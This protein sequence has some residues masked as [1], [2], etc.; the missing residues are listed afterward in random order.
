MKNKVNLI[1]N[2]GRDPE[3]R[4]MPNGD[5]VV[6]LAIATSERWTDKA[7]GE[8][9]ENTEWHRVVIFNQHLC[10]IAEQYL[11]KGSKVDLDDGKLQ[12][13]KWTDKDGIERYTTE[14][15]LDRFGGELV[16]LDTASKN[17]PGF[18]D[19][20]SAYG[21]TSTKTNANAAPTGGSPADLDDEIPL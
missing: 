7:T 5:K 2:L 20:P 6:N 13:R 17:G 11:K 21:N 8:K 14:V 9:K 18:A 19:D 4:S 15:V 16:M 3:V 1:G 12:T 10:G